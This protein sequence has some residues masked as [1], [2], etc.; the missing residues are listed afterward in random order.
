MSPDSHQ[1]IRSYIAADVAEGIGN[2]FRAQHL[3]GP[4]R[5]ES[6]SHRRDF[7]RRSVAFD[8]GSQLPVKIESWRLVALSPMSCFLVERCRKHCKSNYDDGGKSL[9]FSSSRTVVSSAAR[10]EIRKR[11]GVMGHLSADIFSHAKRVVNNCVLE[12]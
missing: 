2:M 8:C 1:F 3:E 11:N 4:P 12:C 7:D 9:L 6:I 10:P 5:R